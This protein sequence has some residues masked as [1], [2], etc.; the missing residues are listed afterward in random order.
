MHPEKSQFYPSQVISFLGFVI[1]S[2]EMT[3]SLSS[4]KKNALFNL[5]EKFIKKPSATIREVSSL[6]G[7][8]TSSFP[9]V[10]FAKLHYR[11]IES[12]KIRA[13]KQQCGNYDK[14]MTL[15]AKAIEELWWWKSNILGSFNNITEGNPEL[16]LTTDAS[17]TGWG[18]VIDG[19]STGG[20]W[21]TT[22]QELHINVLELKA[23]LFGL[24]A[25]FDKTEI[26]YI[27]IRSD[28]T[29]TVCAI[30]KMG[31]AHSKACNFVSKEIWTWVH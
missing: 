31:T 21:N 17:K 28:N 4:E 24:Q 19:G 18:A 14:K 23:V 29:T 10:R 30:N 1:N 5:G 11:Q 6:L 3:I 2:K 16:I 26:K 22:E 27:H 13:L 9:G 12:N 7:K 25:L 15:G 8:I 20:T